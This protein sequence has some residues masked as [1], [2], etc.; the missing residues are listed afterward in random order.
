[1]Q[2]TSQIIGDQELYETKKTASED[3]SFVGEAAEQETEADTFVRRRVTVYRNGVKSNGRAMLIERDDWAFFL[4]TA[5]NKLKLK[6]ASLVFS[7]NG[8]PISSIE[9]VSYQE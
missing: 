6:K 9:Q 4:K 5:G 8:E 3:Q 7:M 1:M 2:K